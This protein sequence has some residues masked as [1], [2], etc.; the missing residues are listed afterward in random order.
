MH[1]SFISVSEGGQGFWLGIRHYANLSDSSPGF[2]G[3]NKD[4]GFM[5]DDGTMLDG[6]LLNLVNTEPVRNQFKTT[7]VEYSAQID[8][9]SQNDVFDC[10]CQAYENFV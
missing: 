7:F 9:A 10:F 4:V 1:L 8:D 6:N 3:R 5:W 2:S